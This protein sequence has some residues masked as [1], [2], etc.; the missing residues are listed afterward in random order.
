MLHHSWRR[1]IDALAW[2]FCQSDGGGNLSERWS[3]RPRSRHGNYYN[4]QA[5]TFATAY[6]VSDCIYEEVK[7]PDHSRFFACNWQSQCTEN[8]TTLCEFD[9]RALAHGII[10]VWPI[11]QSVTRLGG[12]RVMPCPCRP[13]TTRFTW[14]TLTTRIRQRDVSTLLKLASLPLAKRSTIRSINLGTAT[15]HKDFCSCENLRQIFEKTQIR[16]DIDNEA[17]QF[18]EE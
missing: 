2:S 18:S 17:F 6:C 3:N 8:A 16:C 5:R 12:P 1:I 7:R 13:D 15:G 11:E 9:T 4:E 14:N 10:T